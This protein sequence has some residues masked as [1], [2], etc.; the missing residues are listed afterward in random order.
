MYNNIQVINI[1]V[2]KMKASKTEI[3]PTMEQKI[4]INKAFGVGRYLYNLYLEN[5]EEYYDLYDEYLTGFSF[6][7]ILNNY[8][9]PN[10]PDKSW[11]K[12]I[13][14]KSIKK[15][16]MNGDTAYR[17]FFKGESQYPKKKKKKPADEDDDDDDDFGDD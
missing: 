14:S 2:N 12:E 5:Q 17:K 16:I 9:C 3:D 8:Y 6:H 11:I 13:N 1:Q 4:K 15:A 10:N 7:K